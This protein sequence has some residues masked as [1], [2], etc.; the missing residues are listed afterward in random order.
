MK[1][2]ILSLVVV[3]FAEV[4][5]AKD[6]PNFVWI[7]S[8]DN[9]IHYLDHFFPNGADTPNIKNM[10]A[11]GV[12]FE[13]AFS[14]APVCS[15][16]RSTLITS[17]YAPRIGAQYHRRS[18]LA[19]MPEGLK[20]F[21]SYLR[22]KGYYTTNRSKTDYN[23]KQGKDVWDQSSRKAHWKNRKSGQPFFHKASY[24]ISHESSLHFKESAIEN[25]PTVNKSKDVILAPYHPNTKT[26]RYTQARYLDNIVRIDEVVG[27]IIE[28]LQ[29]DGLL[30]DTFVFYFGDHGGVLPRSKGY[31]YETGLHV[32]LVVRIPKNFKHLVKYSNGYREQG[33]VEFVDFGPTLLNLVGIELPN[34]VDGFPF[35]GRGSK[36][37]SFTFN[38]ADRFD[39]KYDF[40]R[41]LRKG[42]FSYQR[43]YQPFNFD[44]IQ[45]DYRYKQ[46]AFTEWRNL[47]NGGRLNPIQSQFFRPRSPEAL[48][49]ISNDPYETNNLAIDPKY[50]KTLSEMRD[51]LRSEMLRTNDLSFYPEPVMIE[52]AM[53]N[54]VNFG[55]EKSENIKRMSELADLQLLP[56]SKIKEP[57]EKALNSRDPWIR[58][59][60]CIVASSH[61]QIPEKM[62]DRIKVI[63]RSDSE[64][65]VRTRAAEFLGI[66]KKD[67]PFPII[68]QALKMAGSDIETNLILNTAVLLQDGGYGYNFESLSMSD[69]NHKGRYVEAR[70]AYLS[71]RKK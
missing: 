55:K 62:I 27:G 63:A 43:N 40:V 3:F 65:L 21:P 35:M 46:L 14:N 8:E 2:T 9:S 4:I 12:T 10:A 66:A 18:M 50:Q 47:Y 32:P 70:I 19:P 64:S 33:F 67:D 31:A 51:L 49:D 1:S 37:R 39:E 28:D 53:S 59:W 61:I 15:V 58:Y 34:G 38:Y 5:F 11:N 57:L 44:G 29:K 45:N 54:P 52:K 6:K 7:I 48:Y 56:I 23:L 24:A 13:N 41:W 42:K 22:D 71:E 68:K 25:Q 17:C 20:M 36:T 69:V 16:A 60:A 26:F 30:E